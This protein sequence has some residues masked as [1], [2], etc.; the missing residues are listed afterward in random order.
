M[1]CWIIL[2]YIII[3]DILYVNNDYWLKLLGVL[4]SFGFGNM[5]IKRIYYEIFD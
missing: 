4:K 3:V 1:F 5:N 2:F